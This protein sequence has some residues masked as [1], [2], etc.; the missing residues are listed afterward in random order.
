MSKLPIKIQVGIRDSWDSKDASAQKAI[1]ALRDLVGIGVFVTPEWPLLHAE[2][3]AFYPD[4][5]TFV[6]SVTAAVEACCTAL[7]GLL[8]DDANADW[9][10]TLL[11]RAD[12]HIRL[13]LEV[14]KGRDMGIAW[15]DQ[16]R[17]FV[18]TLPRAAVPSHSYMISFFGPGLLRVFESAGGQ[19][20]AS[21]LAAETKTTSAEAAD[22]W[23]DVVVDKSASGGRV[24]SVVESAPRQ[25]YQ[26]APQTA[27]AVPAAPGFDLMP[28]VGIVSRPDDLLLKPPYHLIVQGAG[29]S[30]ID[31]QCSH[32]PTL[33][34]LSDYLK[35][36]SK[37][38]HNNT[39]RP[40]AAEVKIHQSAFGLGV[41]YDRLTISSDSRYTGQLVSPTILLS[42]IEG[43]LGYKSVSSDVSS[44]TFRREVEFKSSRY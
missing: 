40:P 18:I 42:L 15:S 37:T 6:P 44:W 14:S 10:D 8:D 43:V 33:Q 29:S 41:V 12:G 5:A 21:P 19:H 28:D 4:K 11:E 26:S 39:T 36:W 23:A 30:Q 27:A 20:D 35:K 25:Q 9:S 32:S 3:G 2:L 38:N 24:V 13:F 17:G 34:F 1:Q 7:A 16:Q 31:V 22:D